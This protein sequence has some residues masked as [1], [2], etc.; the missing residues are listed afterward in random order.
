MNVKYTPNTLKKI[1]QLFEEARFRIRYEKG[2]FAS[3]YCLLE[4]RQI[5]VI[6]KFLNIEGRINALLEIVPTIHVVEEDLSDEIRKFYNQIMNRS[7]SSE[8]TVSNEL[9]FEQP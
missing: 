6:N 3:G 5:A 8:D 4:S 1:E 7:Q 9:N 2:T